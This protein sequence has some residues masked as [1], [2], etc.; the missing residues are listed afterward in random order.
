LEL[1]S[2]KKGSEYSEGFEHVEFVIDEPFE[3]FI[4]RYPKTLFD[5]KG[6]FKKVNAD[7][8]IQ[9][10]NCSV[11]FHHHSLEYVIKYLD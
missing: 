4:K 9:F 5:K 7:L 10:E 2:P 6:Q 1:P 8:R 11:K 3:A